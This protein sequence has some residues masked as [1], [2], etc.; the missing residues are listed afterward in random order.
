M[1]YIYTVLSLFAIVMT[2]DSYGQTQIE[3]GNF[4]TWESLGSTSE[5]PTEWSSLKTSTDDSWLNLANQSPQVIWNETNNPHSGLACIRLKVAAYNSLAGVSPNAIVTNGHVF[6]STNPSNAYV[7]SDEADAKWNT[8]CNTKPDSLVGWYKYSPQAGDK[9]KVEILFHTNSAEGLLP[10][11]GTTNHHVGNGIVEF[12]SV[13]AVWTRFSFPINYTLA[14]DPNYFLIVATAGD[15]LNAQ[16]NSELWLDDMSF[17]YNPVSQPTAINEITIPFSIFSNQN[18]INLNLLNSY[19][20]GELSLYSL[21][22]KLVWN[23]KSIDTNN[24]FTPE[25]SKGIY[26]YQLMIDNVLY[27]GKISLN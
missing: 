22:G 1:N 25:L 24:T 9:G 8:V 3:N 4:E 16:E 13:K 23:K 17:I 19:S 11:N 26:V 10:E 2:N 15:E 18:I 14:A 7:F 5:E 21:E 6:A 27:S 20:K 12:T